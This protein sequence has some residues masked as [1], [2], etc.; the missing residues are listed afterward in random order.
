MKL[1][2]NIRVDLCSTGMKQ[3]LDECPCWQFA[4]YVYYINSFMYYVFFLSFALPC[5]KQTSNTS[6]MR[7]DT[8][9]LYNIVILEKPKMCPTFDRID[10]GA[11]APKPLKYSV[12]LIA[13]STIVKGNVFLTGHTWFKC[14]YAREK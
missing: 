4:N 13:M 2:R 14:H 5:M 6:Y 10:D 3:D 8:S 12:C 1:F 7:L 11:R 9:E